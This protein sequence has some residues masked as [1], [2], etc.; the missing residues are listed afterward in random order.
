MF[1]V[2]VYR[3]C[4]ANAAARGA[5]LLAFAGVNGLERMEE[6]VRETEYEL[7]SKTNPELYQ[8]YCGMRASYVDLQKEYLDSSLHKE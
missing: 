8:A 5:A 6:L 3:G 1:G 7:V 2:D 4:S